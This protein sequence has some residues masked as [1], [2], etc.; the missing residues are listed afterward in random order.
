LLNPESASER[1]RDAADLDKAL[2]A[3]TLDV[4]L[5]DGNC[6]PASSKLWTR[7][8]VKVIISTELQTRR[9]TYGKA[10]VGW[11]HERVVIE[12]KFVGGVSDGRFEMHCWTRF[13]LRDT[14]S[15]LSR[16]PSQDLRSV[17]K[18]GVFGR[19][20]IGMTPSN[21]VGEEAIILRPDL[22][23]VG[24]LYPALGKRPLVKIRTRFDDAKWCDRPP[25]I[26]ELLLMWDVPETVSKG[27]PPDDKAKL[28]SSVKVPM[29]VRRRLCAS[30]A[31]RLEAYSVAISSVTVPEK[32][33]ATKRLNVEV[34]PKGR[35]S[36]Q[37][38]A[39]VP[40]CENDEASR[41]QEG[42]ELAE[43]E[44]DEAEQIVDE[45][46]DKSSTTL[47]KRSSDLRAKALRNDDAKVPV[48]LWNGYLETGLSDE[49]KNRDWRYLLK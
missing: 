22:V 18:T 44:I 17:M 7:S 27:L 45:G 1:E 34:E 14:V 19:H 40:E 49:V 37:K 12:H 4:I 20:A 43:M 9:R 10:Q 26:D 15:Q 6:L 46:E 31:K 36:L 3:Q 21:L 16:V 24:G 8:D 42:R 39:R 28:E 5:I 13:S 11:H 30:L 23:S 25:S 33:K 38:R 2:L 35:R 41:G 32:S 48:E 29:R 47:E